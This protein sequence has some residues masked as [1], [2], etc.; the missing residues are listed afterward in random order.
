MAIKTTSKNGPQTSSFS[1]TRVNSRIRKGITAGFYDIGRQLRRDS[2]KSILDKDKT[3]RVYTRR[4]N[5][6]RVRHQASA[7]GEAPANFTGKL[8]RTITYKIRKSGQNMEFRAGSPKVQ[9][10]R[11]LELG[12]PRVA[13]RPYLK[14]S[15]D[16]N[17]NNITEFFDRNI[18]K[19]LKP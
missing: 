12:T 13:K 7:P 11:G 8:K 9:Y 3:G 10:A 18:R 2:V 1:L 17:Q 14:K 15:I 5:G 19:F 6:R 4:L 16:L